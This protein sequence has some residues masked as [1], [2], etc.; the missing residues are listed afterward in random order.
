LAFLHRHILQAALRRNSR[1]HPPITSK[2]FT[3]TFGRHMG[4]VAKSKIFVVFLITP[5]PSLKL[6]FNA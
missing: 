3:D 2:G 4:F 6:E 1:R 5:N